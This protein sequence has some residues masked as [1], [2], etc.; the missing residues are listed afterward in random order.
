MQIGTISRR[1]K[2][3]ICKIAATKKQKSKLVFDMDMKPGISVC[4]YYFNPS[5]RLS[6]NYRMPLS[7]SDSIESKLRQLQQLLYEKFKSEW[8]AAQED[9]KH[10]KRLWGVIQNLFYA[11]QRDIIQDAILQ[12]G[13]K[14]VNLVTHCK[15]FIDRGV[16]QAAISDMVHLML[17][18]GVDESA[19]VDRKSVV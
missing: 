7:R 19:Y 2:W 13:A 15:D 17:L 8:D 16:Q 14:T 1:C 18:N 12:S 11:V 9:R 4:M 6:I 10:R 3:C 5:A